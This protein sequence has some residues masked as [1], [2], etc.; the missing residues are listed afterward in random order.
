VDRDYMVVVVVAHADTFCKLHPY[1]AGSS[2]WGVPTVDN[3]KRLFRGHGQLV[4]PPE[5]KIYG[6]LSLS[7]GS[8]SLDA[9]HTSP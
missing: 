4:Q 2:Q 3:C 5:L 8:L 9:K 1:D 7:D 6:Q